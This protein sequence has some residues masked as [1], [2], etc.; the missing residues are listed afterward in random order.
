MER[1]NDINEFAP[2][3]VAPYYPQKRK[4]EGW[5]LVIGD[6]ELN[7]LLSIKRYY[8]LK[9]KIIFSIFYFRLTVN[10]K[11]KAELDFVPSHSGKIDFKLYFMC[12]SYLGADQEFDIPLKI[13]GFFIYLFIL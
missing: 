7:Q 2:P 3:V 5:W 10:A 8:L 1:E 11:A 13:S 12:D 6:P 4:E 9:K